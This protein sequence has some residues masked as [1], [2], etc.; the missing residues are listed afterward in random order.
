VA[1]N[2]PKS[3]TV[4]KHTRGQATQKAGDRRAERSP[5]TRAVPQRVAGRRQAQKSEQATQRLLRAVTQAQSLYID[6]AK[7]EQVFSSLLQELLDLTGSEY[8]FIGEVCWTAERV[9]FLRTHAITDIA[10][11]EEAKALLAR[12]A[13]NL[14][15]HNLKTLFGHVMTSGRP[16]IANDPAHDPRAGELPPGHPPMHAFLGLPFYRGEL[17]TGMVGVAN[18]RGGY[19]ETVVAY[20][21]PFLATCAQLLE[22]CRHRRLRAEAETALR[23]S[24][25][26]WRLAVRGSHDGI[27]NWNITTGEVFVSARWKAMRGFEDQEITGSFKVWREGI[28][29]DDRDRVLHAVDVYLAKQSP[30]FCEEYRVRRKDGSYI[31][32][33]DRGVALWD[34]RWARS[35]RAARRSPISSR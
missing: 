1:R 29:P 16:V 26:R 25:E 3:R 33:L 14:E 20:L 5:T 8:G 24:E 7:P 31:W 18:R 30:E 23:R 6:E 11:K 13:P 15:F 28:Y 4:T 32:V 35:T 17:L 27:W 12:S 22:G 10:W 21:A 19:D 2:K 34:D 9:P